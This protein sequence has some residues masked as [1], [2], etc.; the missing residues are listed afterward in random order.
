MQR[1]EW[2]IEVSFGVPVRPSQRGKECVE[3][4][5]QVVLGNDDHVIQRESV[6][7]R[8]E[9]DQH[10]NDGGGDPGRRTAVSPRSQGMAAAVGR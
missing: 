7:Q 10:C 5:Q 6:A 4:V 9:V 2:P 1:G 3:L 8:R